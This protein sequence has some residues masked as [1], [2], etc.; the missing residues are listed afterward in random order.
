MGARFD[1]L[2]FLAGTLWIGAYFLGLV[3][4][5]LRV[6]FSPDDTMNLYRPWSFGT[7]LLIEA[8]LIF[9]WTSPIYRPF[10]SAWYAII[11]HFA[12]FHPRPFHAVY[13]V[14]LLVDIILTYSVTQR[15]SGSRAAAA[16]AAVL[17]SYHPAFNPLY[18]DT[19]YVFDVLCYLL[20]FAAFLLYVRVRSNDRVLTARELAICCL[21]YICALNSKEMAVTLPVTLLSYELVYHPRDCWRRARTRPILLTVIITL[22]FAI[23][24]AIGPETLLSIDAYR[25]I[26]R[27]ARYLETSRHFFSEVFFPGSTTR[28][29]AAW[30]ILLLIAVLSH[31]RVLRFAWVF[32]MLAPLPVAFILPRGAAQYYVPWFGW[33]LFGSVV[34]VRSLEFLTR[35]VPLGGDTLARVRGIALIMFLTL[36]LFPYYKHI[37]W[38][39]VTSVSTEAPVIRDTVEQ[40]HSMYKQFPPGSR[41]LFKSDPFRPD[42]WTLTF[43]VRE[44][45]RDDSLQVFRVKQKDLRADERQM[46]DHV[47]DYREGRFLEMRS[48]M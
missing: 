12:G 11:Y 25:P 37:G 1:R 16:V 15:L 6:Y 46:Y 21:L 43:L 4:P 47:F 27:A 7:R 32:L 34:V 9:F 39:S 17:I 40:L 44:S 33:V 24:R 29:L 2:L 36:V 10:A 26:L 45:Y 30:A 19:A 3:W 13:I 41:L 28:V 22:V 23:G 31:S 42:Q 14:L 48:G 20:Y 5:G 18:F 35:G 38:R 8:N